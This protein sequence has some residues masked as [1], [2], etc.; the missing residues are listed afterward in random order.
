LIKAIAECE[1]SEFVRRDDLGPFAFDELEEELGACIR[2][3]R[4]LQ[5]LPLTEVPSQKLQQFRNRTNELTNKLQEI[6]DFNPKT[7]NDPTQSHNS[8]MDQF[9][10]EWHNAF[11]QLAPY[12]SYLKPRGAAVEGVVERGREML[13]DLERERDQLRS[14]MEEARQESERILRS[15]R[16]AAAEAGVEQHAEHFDTEAGYHSAGARRWLWATGVLAGFTGLLAGWFL[17]MYL[18]GRV[19]F[20]GEEWIQVAVAKVV[21]FSLLYFGI[22]WCGRNYRSHKHN[23]VINKHRRN[24]LATFRAFTD[25]ATDEGTKNAVLIRATEAIFS[26]GISGYMPDQQEGGQSPQVLEILRSFRES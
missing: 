20:T 5:E 21:L 4:D 2:F 25:A 26:P 13:Q 14:E 16:S 18:T 9:R 12:A 17:W 11:S 24:A 7:V 22:V 1:I 15:L 3:Y 19:T 23:H 6:R 8:L 10:Q